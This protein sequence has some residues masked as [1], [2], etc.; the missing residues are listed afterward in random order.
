MQTFNSV[1]C[2]FSPNEQSMILGVIKP[3]TNNLNLFL[4]K[5]KKFHIFLE[6]EKE[7]Y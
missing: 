7:N 3:Q 6:K 1:S 4:L 5:V 2:H